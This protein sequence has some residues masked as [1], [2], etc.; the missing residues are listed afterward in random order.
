MCKF[1]CGKLQFPSAYIWPTLKVF[2]GQTFLG[3]QKIIRVSVFPCSLHPSTEINCSPYLSG[4][5]KLTKN[6]LT[7]NDLPKQVKWRMISQPLIIIRNVYLMPP[8]HWPFSLFGHVG[9]IFVRFVFTFLTGLKKM[10]RSLYILLENKLKILIR[11][12]S[13]I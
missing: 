13:S 7:L 12:L 4:G 3:H 2:Q 1:F 11:P 9:S 8:F 6:S 5:Q 10:K